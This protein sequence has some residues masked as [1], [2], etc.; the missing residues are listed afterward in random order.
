[1]SIMN[2]ISKFKTNTKE[3]VLKDYFGYS[4]FRK[5][6]SEIIDNIM[7]GNDVL[8]VMPTGAGK[9]L[10]FQVPALLFSDLT[11]VISPLISLMQD[12]VQALQ[13]A[14]VKAAFL[15]SSLSAKEY[16]EV[17]EDAKCGDYKILYIAPERLDNPDFMELCQS[18]KISMVTIDEAHCVS[19]WG[20]DFRPSYL[21]I[22]NFIHRLPNRP[23]ITAFTATATKEVRADIVK[24]LELQNPFTITT[25]F[26]R[27]NLYFET[28]ICKSGKTKLEYIFK[29]LK[30]NKDLSGI[31]YCATRKN[32]EMVEAE[33]IKAGYNATMYH[34][35]ISEKRRS[36]NQEDFQ[37]DKKNIMVATNAFGMGI[38]KSNVN[39]VVHFNMPKNLENYYQEAGRAGRDG[40]DAKCIL[41]FQPQDVQTQNFFIEH[42][43][44]QALSFEEQETVKAADREKLQK[45]KFYCHTADCLRS[46][47]LRYFGDDAIE[48]CDNCSSCNTAHT[49]IDITI[50]AQKILSCVARTNGKYGSKIIAAT[51]HGSTSKRVLDLGLD[52][53]S[54]YGI[55]SS[56]KERQ[57][58][59]NID[60]LINFGYL[61]QTTSQFPVLFINDKS[62]QVLFEGLKVKKR[63]TAQMFE[64][65]LE[66]RRSAKSSYRNH[67]LSGE[68]QSL[69]GHLKELRFQ[70]AEAQK[71]PAFVVF[72]DATLIDMCHKLPKTLDDMLDVSGVGQSKLNKYGE[73]FL[74]IIK[75]Y[76]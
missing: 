58:T 9:S 27:P 70:L 18:A 54:T 39:F 33:L 75:K 12:Q 34:A 63:I 48:S 16:Y 8:G 11:I 69:F 30:K 46:Y 49:E 68:N 67:R 24:I 6:Q 64:E 66:E 42:N 73:D 43:D 37:F 65:D 44:N 25:G 38:D 35:G 5:G 52:E 20:Q 4:S 21:K 2:F 74:E 50:E 1:M 56:L 76:G 55:M 14:G 72:S 23:I 28:Q 31:I 45:I 7:A 51:L 61:S 10:C 19:Q 22:K 17:L 57:I 71:V 15:N 47:I 13:T 62:K 59:D 60:F 40:T 32:V 53:L 26:D 41:L 36:Q 3:Q 29:F